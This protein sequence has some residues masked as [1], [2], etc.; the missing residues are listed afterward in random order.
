MKDK[1]K[2]GQYRTDLEWE[3]IEKERDELEAEKERLKSTVDKLE[4]IF[5][6]LQNELRAYNKTPIK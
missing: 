5:D 3:S 2:T 1:T 4:V 6:N